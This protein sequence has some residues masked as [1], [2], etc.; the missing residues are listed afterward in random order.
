MTRRAAQILKGLALTIV[1]GAI[2]WFLSWFMQ[3]VASIT[4]PGQEHELHLTGTLANR[5]AFATVV[6]TVAIMIVVVLAIILDGWTMFWISLF[7]SLAGVFSGVGS[8]A[9]H[10]FTGTTIATEAARWIY[11]I[12]VI[13]WGILMWYIFLDDVTDELAND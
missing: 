7:A 12:V 2:T 5:L 9:L 10:T 8:I 13:L 6:A 4:I 1:A 3:Y 11:G